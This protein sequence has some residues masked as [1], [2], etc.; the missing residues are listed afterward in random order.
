MSVITRVVKITR[1]RNREFV[2]ALGDVSEMIAVRP[3]QT[4]IQGRLAEVTEWY[5]P[6][7][8]DGFEITVHQLDGRDK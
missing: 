4:Q 6:T 5:H 1:G 7:T 2:H 3:Y 8:F